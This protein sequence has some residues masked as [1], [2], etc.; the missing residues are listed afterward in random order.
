[1]KKYLH[2]SLKKIS[3]ALLI[4]KMQEKKIKINRLLNSIKKH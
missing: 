4:I 2:Y 3:L 1:M